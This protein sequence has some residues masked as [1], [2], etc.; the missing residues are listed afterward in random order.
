LKSTSSSASK[1]S[2]QKSSSSKVR[3]APTASPKTAGATADPGRTDCV[4][5]PLTGI[6]HTG[7]PRGVTVRPRYGCRKHRPNASRTEI[8][9]SR[10]T[11]TLL[12]HGSCFPRSFM[13]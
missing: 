12:S 2:R 4:I 8:C 5:D 11:P 10:T 9:C 6:V 13:S 7:L 3:Q 1:S